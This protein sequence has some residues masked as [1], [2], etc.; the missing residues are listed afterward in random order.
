MVGAGAWR[1]GRA[2]PS[3][4]SPSSFP[5]PAA[6]GGMA[7][8]ARSRLG[9]VAV[10]ALVVAIFMP[11]AAV[12]Q[13]P[14]PAPTSD[15]TCPP[16]PCPPI[17]LPSGIIP[18]HCDLRPVVNLSPSRVFS[19]DPRGWI[20]EGPRASVVR[21][22]FVHRFS[23]DLRCSSSIWFV[24]SAIWKKVGALCLFVYVK[25]QKKCRHDF[26][27]TPTCALR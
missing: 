10:A 6:D 27:S 3:V 19:L 11:A 9:A 23:K 13:A 16:V 21:P 12:A 17:T 26:S 8:A 24:V 7:A 2:V 1:G 15:G 20:V 25:R 5:A 4:P 18:P 22:L 14:A